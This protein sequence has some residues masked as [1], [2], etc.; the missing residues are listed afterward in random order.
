MRT[1]LAGALLT[2][3]CLIPGLAAAWG[4]EGHRIV[5][6]IAYEHLSPDI[7]AEV[8]QM[9]A[10]DPDTLTKHSIADAATWADRYRDSDRFSSKKRYNLTRE[11]HFVDLRAGPSRSRRSMLRASPA[12]NTGE[13]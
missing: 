2:A 7:Q 3:I 11:W 5:A 6:L 1:I 10:A 12:S 13:C 4:D 8:G 9:L